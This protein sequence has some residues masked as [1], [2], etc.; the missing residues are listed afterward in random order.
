MRLKGQARKAEGAG[1]KDAR[2]LKRGQGEG[3]RTRARPMGATH[4]VGWCHASSD[5]TVHT[6]LRVGRSR[7]S[8]DSARATL[9]YKRLFY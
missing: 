6:R 1:A 9:E 4:L 2:E 7:H 3:G 5:Q 8:K